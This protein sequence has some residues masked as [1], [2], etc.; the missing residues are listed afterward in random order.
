LA[1]QNK[2]F[3]QYEYKYPQV[4]ARLLQQCEQAK[5]KLSSELETQIRLPDEQGNV[6]PDRPSVTITRDMLLDCC[7]PILAK[8]VSPVRRALADAKLSTA[9]IDEVILV[10]GATRTPAIA[11]LVTQLFDRPPTCRLNPDE[12]V[13]LGAA[14]QAALVEDS[15][16]VEDLVVVDVAPFSLGISTS[17][18]FGRDRQTGYFSPIIHRN[19]IIPT[20]R[21]EIFSTT[22]PWQDE[23][24]IEVYQGESRKVSDNLFIGKLVA[25]GIPATLHLQE[26]KIRFTYD[27][28]GVLEVEAEVVAT[29]KKV[30]AVFANHARQLDDAGIAA[31]VNRMQSLKFHPR[32]DIKNIQ[33]M[34]RAERVFREL[35]VEIRASLAERIDWFEGA[36]ESQEPGRIDDA[37]QELCRFLDLHDAEGESF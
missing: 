16:H 24:N 8:I 35:P 5:R 26:V 21:V 1:H 15:R 3:E 14:V 20:S 2:S 12:V 30:A 17:K 37:Y 36:L 6:G 4:L 34:K 28:N 22:Q 29:G 19:T 10:G 23:M 31:A 9:A 27:C 7:Q 11:E 13:A 25:K 33:L 32:D 18:Q